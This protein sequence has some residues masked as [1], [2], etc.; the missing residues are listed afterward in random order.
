MNKNRNAQG[1]FVENRNTGYRW[2]EQD[3]GELTILR[4]I[5]EK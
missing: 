2:E 1:V 4:W 3:V 5:F